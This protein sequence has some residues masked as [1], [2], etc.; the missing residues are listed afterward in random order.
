VRVAPAARSLE[1]AA[2][3]LGLTRAWGS[4]VILRAE[5]DARS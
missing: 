4:P 5:R 1:A 3:V 2:G